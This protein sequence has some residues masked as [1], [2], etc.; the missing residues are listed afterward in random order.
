MSVNTVLGAGGPTGLECVKRL[1]EATSSPVRAVVRDPEKYKE[2][3]PQDSRLEIVKGDVTDPDSLKAAFKDSKAVIFAA[4]GQGF[5]TAA[6]VDNQGVANT[7]EAAKEAGVDQVVLVSSMLVHPSNRFN[8]I[9]IILNNVRWSLMDNKFQGEEKLRQSGVPYTIVRPA[10]LTN[11]PGGQA[12]LV[13]D[14]NTTKEVA[15]KPGSIARA[16]V[17]AICVA[18]LTKPAAKNK[19]L[20]V[21]TSGKSLSEGTSQQAELDRLFTTLAA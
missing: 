10:G 5:W 11:G 20:S 14:V 8:P 18:A 7:A 9:R 4:S 13:A 3:L 2:R 16:D 19:T 6:P 1:L 17:A 12:P 21:Y 15:Q